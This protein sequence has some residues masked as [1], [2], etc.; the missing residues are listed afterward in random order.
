M[1]QQTSLWQS[2]PQSAVFAE[3]CNALYERELSRLANGDLASVEGIK[4]RLKSLS[5]YI[6]TTADLMTRVQTP[7]DIDNQNA[8]WS[9]PQTQKLPIDDQNHESIFQWYHKTTLKPGLVIPIALAHRIVLDSITRVDK[10]NNRFRTNQYGWF[11]VEAS[12]LEKSTLDNAYNELRFMLLK[13]TKRVMM[14]ACAGH[15]WQNNHKVQPY[16]PSLLELRL[17]CDINW[18]NFKIIY[19]V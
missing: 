14:A 15:S 3:L 1:T 6:K 5:Y 11:T 10:D 16:I 7:L 17:S 4:G 9:C 13:P 12:A 18:K 19:T 8:T 2:D